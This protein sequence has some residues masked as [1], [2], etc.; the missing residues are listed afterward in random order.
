M[1]TARRAI[2]FSMVGRRGMVG[3]LGGVL[4]FAFWGLNRET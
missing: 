4:S 2:G 1:L 3:A